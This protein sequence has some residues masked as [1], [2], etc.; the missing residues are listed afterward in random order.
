MADLTEK[1]TADSFKGFKDDLDAMLDE[2]SGADY[3]NALLDDDDAAI[4]RLL[5][6]PDYAEQSEHAQALDDVD[7]L[8]NASAQATAVEVSKSV[9]KAQDQQIDALLDQANTHAQANT[10]EPMDAYFDL[11][12]DPHPSFIS[13]GLELETDI[14]EHALQDKLGNAA[15]AEPASDAQDDSLADVLL[16]DLNTD[17]L[18]LDTGFDADALDILLDHQAVAKPEPI[19]VAQ[20]PNKDDLLDE[21]DAL[22]A[23]ATLDEPNELDVMQLSDLD[24][25]PADSRSTATATQESSNAAD[26]VEQGQTAL[27]VAHDSAD[28]DEEPAMSQLVDEMLSEALADLQRETLGAEDL[29]DEQ[30]EFDITDEADAVA[31]VNAPEVS[32][33]TLQEEPA[34]PVF[35]DLAQMLDFNLDDDAFGLG[36]SDPEEQNSDDLELEVELQQVNEPALELE[37]D[38]ETKE[39]AVEAQDD[40]ERAEPAIIPDEQV[41]T[42]AASVVAPE[43]GLAED[44]LDPNPMDK[45]TNV[46]QVPT[47]AEPLTELN[48]TRPEVIQADSE[49]A[50]TPTVIDP[51]EQSVAETDP[52]PASEASSE[53]DF[54]MADFD[55]SGEDLAE[56]SLD[57]LE[58]AVEPR[59]EPADLDVELESSAAQDDLIAELDSQLEGQDDSLSADLDLSATEVDIDA[60]MQAATAEPLAVAESS[61][62]ALSAEPVAEP[63]ASYIPP[64]QAP[65]E[66]EAAA[67]ISA[68]WAAHDLLRQQ[69][70]ASATQP[71]ANEFL[72]DEL[73]MLAKEQKVLRRNIDNQNKKSPAMLY[74]A[75]GLGVTGAL[76]GVGVLTMSL[77]GSGELS[78][79]QE[80]SN[81]LQ[82][83]LEAVKHNTTSVN[84]EEINAALSQLTVKI[85]ALEKNALEHNYAAQLEALQNTVN[86]LKTSLANKAATQNPM[87]D[88]QA[89]KTML[90]KA[91][92]VKTDAPVSAPPPPAPVATPVKPEVVAKTA[93]LKPPKAA[94]PKVERP[95]R[96]VA[97]VVK[98]KPKA[99][100]ENESPAPVP[101]AGRWVANLISFRQDWYAQ[102]KAAE[103]ARQGIY[104]Q[105]VPV[106]VKGETW[107]RLR[108]NNFASKN[109]AQNFAAKAKRQLNLTSVWVADE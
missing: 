32:T 61:T 7:A 33:P 54:L 101:P 63:P 31:E 52:S 55:I 97:E 106:Q 20:A 60:L 56:L 95:P 38:A 90:P 37:A 3:S 44:T 27:E 62:E 74:T 73:E 11:F 26:T 49:I 15:K 51:Q 93:A 66:Q 109:E 92:V 35:D 81:T 23:Q 42:A 58:V 83:E 78:E 28:A 25:S 67:Q 108:S 47:V 76:L 72:A 10:P 36:L 104:V 69:F 1:N 39:I 19:A 88:A 13:S 77:M 8:L 24:E 103:F 100:A 41:M 80:Q 30:A 65:L 22:L 75:L 34:T 12:S 64:E 91:E 84:P 105:V 98:P 16:E 18:I 45:L 71:A 50:K 86:E 46:V 9:P 53:A 21:V 85:D 59:V 40:A 5:M 96:V 29:Q 87:N 14:L 107:Y 102:G 94:P 99:I 79:L 89:V 4:E 48:E 17:A 68:L 82:T 57:A 70:S 2:A 6:G 43:D